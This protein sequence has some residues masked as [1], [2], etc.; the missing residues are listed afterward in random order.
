MRVR[1][2]QGRPGE[3]VIKCQEG[4]TQMKEVIKLIPFLL[5]DYDYLEKYLE[6]QSK[7]G[8]VLDSLGLFY[9]RFKTT[10]PCDR[11]YCVIPSASSDLE[12]EEKSFYEEAGWH[13][14][15]TSG[16]W[17]ILYTD[18]LTSSELFT[19][20]SSFEYHTKWYTRSVLVTCILYL[21]LIWNMIKNI[22]FY[23]DDVSEGMLSAIMNYI[24]IQPCAFIAVVLLTIVVIYSIIKRIKHLPKYRNSNSSGSENYKFVFFCNIAAFIMAVGSVVLMLIQ[25]I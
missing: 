9:G 19:D 12:E 22:M 24:Q 17:S 15:K 6:E 8:L 4:K 1:C 25:G 3:D 11:K 23:Q 5:S 7:N 13:N 21:I 18:D 20:K 16:S 14:V 10:K 2:R